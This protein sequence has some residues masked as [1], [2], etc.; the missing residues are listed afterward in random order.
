M[1]RDDTHPHLHYRLRKANRRSRPVRATERDTNVVSAP[2]N[3]AKLRDRRDRYAGTD[4]R[5][6]H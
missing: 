2:L 5:R 4:A 1:Y 6:T 3:S